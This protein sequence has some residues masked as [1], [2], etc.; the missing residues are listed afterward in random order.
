MRRQR[1]SV[2]QRGPDSYAIKYRMSPDGKQ[3]WEGGF[4]TEEQAQD[5]LDAVLRELRTGEYV[6]PRIVTFADFAEEWIASR[7][8]IRG[9]TLSAYRSLI[10]SHFVPHFGTLRVGAIRPE[11][12]EALVRKLAASVG[13]KTLHNCVTLLRGMMAGKKGRN[14]IKRGYTRYD[15]T[16]GVEI[17]PKETRLIV[18]PTKGA[19]LAVD[20]CCQENRHAFLHCRLSGC[21]H[22]PTTWRDSGPSILGRRLAE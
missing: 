11:S 14:A 16:L 7:K 15:A 18:P 6:E 19:S 13:P 2:I 20:R 1:G 17:A 4:G 3:K 8:S 21:F 9:S 12:V 5:R 22:R 10:R